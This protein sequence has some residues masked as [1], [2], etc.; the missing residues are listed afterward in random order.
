MRACDKLFRMIVFIALIYYAVKF[1][2]GDKSDVV[3]AGNDDVVNQDAERLEK[4]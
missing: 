4:T 1:L 3:V 2:N